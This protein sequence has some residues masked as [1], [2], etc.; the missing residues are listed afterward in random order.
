MRS[1]G[2]FHGGGGMRGGGGGF[3]GG[4]VGGGRSGFV[5]GIR[6]GGFRGGGFHRFGGA[7]V[8]C[9]NRGFFPRNRFFGSS[10]FFGF[11]AF[12]FGSG[13]GY[14]PDIWSPY[15]D[16][17][18]PA[19]GYPGYPSYDPYVG[20]GASAYSAPSYSAPSQVVVQVPPAGAT[21]PYRDQGE[22]RIIRVPAAERY[23]LLAF[24]DKTIKAVT[25]YWLDGNTLNYVTRQ[26]A[27]G[28]AQ[29]A[30]ID[31]SFT[32][33]LNRERDVEFRLPS[34]ASDP[35]GG[36]GGRYQPHRLDDFGRPE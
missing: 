8:G 21:E 31:L 1:G 13:Y 30:D 10:I 29:L 26:G 24:Q 3:R 9:F 12:G 34:P 7:C 25:D 5:G 35:G 19:Y 2:G 32:K 18:P 22:S 16:Y 28:S 23:W 11:P 20:Y 36:S 33:Q 6:G 15:Y 17:P 4:V 27:K 14:W